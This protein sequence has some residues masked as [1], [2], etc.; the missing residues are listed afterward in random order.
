M[1]LTIVVAI[2]IPS[3]LLFGG[4]FTADDS[5]KSMAAH[6]KQCERLGLKQGT[7]EQPTAVW[8][9]RAKQTHAR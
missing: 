7:L 8:S 2:V 5:R 6:S 9:W 3:A 1:R 4:R